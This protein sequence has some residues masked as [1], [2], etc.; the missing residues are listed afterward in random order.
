[1]NR[2]QGLT[3]QTGQTEQAGQ[4]EQF[5]QEKQTVQTGQ[6]EQAVR[7]RNPIAEI[8]WPTLPEKLAGPFH[9]WRLPGRAPPWDRGLQTPRLQR[10]PNNLYTANGLPVSACS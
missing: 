4:T 5:E 2:S 3:G 10:N 1:V 7:Y 9:R 8:L 6:I